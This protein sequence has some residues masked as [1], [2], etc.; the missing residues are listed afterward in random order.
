MSEIPSRSALISAHGWQH[1][2]WVGPFYPDDIPPEWQLTYYANFFHAVV[3]PTDAWGDDPA[4]RAAQWREDVHDNFF[5]VAETPAPAAGL[6][7][8]GE[9]LLATV[10]EESAGPWQHAAGDLHAATPEAPLLAVDERGAGVVLAGVT[11]AEGEPMALRRAWEALR[12]AA[13]VGARVLLVVRGTG[14]ETP[15]VMEQARTVAELLGL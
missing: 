15:P 2:D 5:F 13:P 1:A 8:L 4:A 3:I 11:A 6:E 12:D 7:A 9:A 10:G 14:R